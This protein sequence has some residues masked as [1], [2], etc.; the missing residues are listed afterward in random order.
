MNWQNI[1]IGNCWQDWDI[2]F[3]LVGT[4]FK[5]VSK[6][7]LKFYQPGEPLAVTESFQLTGVVAGTYQL[8]F[9]VKDP[10]GY[11]V[12]MQLAIDG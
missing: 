10:N 12:N 3:E 5:A 7:K 8:R 4:N 11:R 1:G 6:H 9:L 2:V